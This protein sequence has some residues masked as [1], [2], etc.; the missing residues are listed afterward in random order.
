[1]LER[2][3]KF[4]LEEFNVKCT[5]N[6]KKFVGMEIDARDN[7]VLLHQQQMILQLGVD[8][9]IEKF[10]E[11][12]MIPNLTW[13]AN[14]VPLEDLT[15]LQKLFGELN[16]VA[17]LTRPDIAYAV[18]R[19]ARRLHDG[20][21]EVFRAAKRILAYVVGTNDLALRVKAWDS[22]EW[23]MT[24][25]CDASFADVVEDKYKSTGGF[26]LLLNDSIISWKS[27]KMKWVCSSTAEAEYLALYFSTKE[28]LYLGYLV[29]EFFGKEIWPIR[30]KVDNQ[31]VVHVIQ[32]SAPANLTKHM[33]TKFYAVQQ[34]Q[35]EGFIHV[36]DVTSKENLAGCFTK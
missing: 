9:R 20:T 11:T 32:K 35:A 34:W 33:A 2:C 24:L 6:V 25:Y 19:I 15:P 30:V 4:L 17:G 26:L 1:M 8:Y 16:Y 5:D 18:N 29:Q 12:P 3:E 10:P 27:K 22:P 31:A 23:D 7:A 14:S 28:A 36:E 21:K 13:I